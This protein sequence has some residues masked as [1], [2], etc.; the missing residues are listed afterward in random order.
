M[1]GLS[2]RGDLHARRQALGWMYDKDLVAALFEQVCRLC[3]SAVSSPTI[4]PSFLPS[5]IP[6]FP[7]LPWSSAPSSTL[8][9]A[10]VVGTHP[11][12]LPL[13]SSSLPP[14]LPLRRKTDMVSV[15]V[16]T[17]VCSEPCPARETM[18]PWPFWSW[19]RSYS[20]RR[21]RGRE[22]GRGGERWTS[23]IYREVGGGARGEGVR[24]GR[25]REGGREGGKEGWVLTCLSF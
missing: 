4:P 8:Y 15:P 25:W 12:L 22:G 19:S 23:G 7:V 10:P 13:T 11:L 21:G 1:I 2:K 16:A 3:M 17:A 6:S 14:S 24:V 5:F 20:G 9:R 18:P